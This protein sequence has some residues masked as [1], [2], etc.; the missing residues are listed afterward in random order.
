VCGIGTF[1]CWSLAILA[2]W[3]YAVWFLVGGAGF[4]HGGTNAFILAYARP[5]FL[6]SYGTTSGMLT[7]IGAG[8]GFI[9]AYIVGVAADQ[10][11][12][13]SAVLGIGF[14]DLAMAAIA[15]GL[16]RWQPNLVPNG[17]E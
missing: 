16:W 13:T 5:H 12:L 10:F 15:F 11:S 9:L 6:A 17:K 4:F 7:S 1:I 8:G 14:A 3:N 2:E